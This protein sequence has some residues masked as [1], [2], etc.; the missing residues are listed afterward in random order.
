MFFFLAAENS[1]CGFYTFPG[2]KKMVKID[3]SVPKIKV[4]EKKN[5]TCRNQVDEWALNFFPVK[6]YCSLAS[7]LRT[8][9]EMLA[10]VDRKLNQKST[11]TKLT[12]VFGPFG[13]QK[14]IFWTSTKF[15]LVVKGSI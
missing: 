3:K 14:V 1:L 11:I 12:P 5:R 6:K 13:V 9:K 10:L 15:C 2:K 8:N 7:P 4:L